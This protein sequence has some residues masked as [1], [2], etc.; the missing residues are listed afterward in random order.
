MLPRLY[1]ASIIAFADSEY[2]VLTVKQSQTP[3]R[4]ERPL[5]AAVDVQ[6]ARSE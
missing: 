1:C 5:S 2:P 3:A 6:L 4:A